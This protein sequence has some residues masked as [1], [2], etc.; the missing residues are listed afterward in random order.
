MRCE[1]VIEKLPWWINGTLTEEEK[2][3][4]AAHLEGCSGCHAEVEA[5]TQ[6]GHLFDSHIPTLDLTDYGLGL[7]IQGISRAALELHL[8]HCEQCQRELALVRADPGE[9][10]RPEPRVQTWWRPLAIAASFTAILGITWPVWQGSRV[11]PPEGSVEIVEI[12]PD[13]YATRGEETSNEIVEADGNLTVWVLL[14]D[15]VDE[16]ADFRLRVIDSSGKTSWEVS[17]L[18]RSETG[19]FTV[20]APSA[21]LPQGELE[22][23]LEGLGTQGW[24]P[25]ETYTLNVS[26][27]MD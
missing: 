8:S 14:S 17:G 5:V 11:L 25:L 21:K 19:E 4:I 6:A 9:E 12:L 2:Q 13:S 18:N 24:I 3:E 27:K 23:H 26:P 15:R 16:F 20:L 1:T 7:E 10:R 22:V